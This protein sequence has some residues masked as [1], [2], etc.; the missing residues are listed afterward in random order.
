[1]SSAVFNGS[2]AEHRQK[3]VEWAQ[4]RENRFVAFDVALQGPSLKW[5]AVEGFLSRR[6]DAFV[7]TSRD[8]ETFFP[9]ERALY[10]NV[11][12]APSP[13]AATLQQPPQH[14]PSRPPTPETEQ[15]IAIAEHAAACAEEAASQVADLRQ[16]A[17]TR[18]R[19]ARTEASAQI[20]ELK[21]LQQRQ[22]QFFEE[23]QRQQQQQLAEIKSELRALSVRSA[24]ASIRSAS[25][26]PV[27]PAIQLGASASTAIYVPSSASATT[28]LGATSVS[29]SSP[30]APPPAPSS[31]LAS[32]G[33][34][35]SLGGLPALPAASVLR[36][37][38]PSKS[39]AEDRLSLEAESR[40]PQWDSHMLPRRDIFSQ[41]DEL[42]LRHLPRVVLIKAEREYDTCRRAIQAM[43]QFL[44]KHA[45]SSADEVKEAFN[46]ALH[47]NPD[48]DAGLRAETAATVHASMLTLAVA[49]SDSTDAA[50]A[51]CSFALWQ[52]GLCWLRC[53]QQHFSRV[54]RLE[55]AVLA[56]VPAGQKEVAE[57]TTSK[58]P[59]PTAAGI[60]LL[61][62]PSGGF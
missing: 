31:P 6:G 43:T 20:A 24:S 61:L 49:S 17:E 14:Q 15:A 42:V 1:M 47:R 53:S 4:G 29:S 5:D 55:L 57:W 36:Q 32:T 34:A 8:G 33:R 41:A 30:V 62:R 22:M 60:G 51:A 10:R 59:V 56:E 27:A 46:T 25:P 9:A 45:H 3:L 35:P 44:A 7:V 28:A 39:P 58:K 13:P 40:D 16:E 38:S 54:E 23:Q 2:N 50:R 52:L 11:R 48:R 12:T 18:V 19:Q 26:V 37:L 21:Q